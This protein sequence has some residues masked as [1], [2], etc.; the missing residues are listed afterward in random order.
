MTGLL[1]FMAGLRKRFVQQSICPSIHPSILLV[2]CLWKHWLVK[3][4][5]VNV[6]Q[7]E[8]YIKDEFFEMVLQ[9]LELLL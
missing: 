3:I 8:Q 2:L 1:Y 4:C 9:F 5:L 7:E 6:I